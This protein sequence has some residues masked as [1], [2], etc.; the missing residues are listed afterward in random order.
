M[1][2]GPRVCVTGRISLSGRPVNGCSQAA[3]PEK[4]PTRGE[5]AHGLTEVGLFLSARQDSVKVTA[6]Q[7]GLRTDVWSGAAQHIQ[8]AFSPNEWVIERA[9]GGK[10]SVKVGLISKL[11]LATLPSVTS[12][13]SSFHPLHPRT[14]VKIIKQAD[15]K[16]PVVNK[17]LPP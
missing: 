11:P 4:P 5:S 14:S 12:S 3:S 10:L 7:T 6:V 8:E 2:S 17:I 9:Q 16:E 13:S 1:E 15:S